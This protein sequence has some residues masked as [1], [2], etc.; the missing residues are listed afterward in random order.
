MELLWFYIAIVLAIKSGLS[1]PLTVLLGAKLGRSVRYFLIVIVAGAV[2]PL[3]F[4]SFAKLGC[5]E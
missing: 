2:W 4:K 1:T 5:K 3:S